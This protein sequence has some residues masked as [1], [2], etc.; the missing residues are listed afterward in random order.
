MGGN[1]PPAKSANAAV[2]STE[3]Y[4]LRSGSHARAFSRSTGPLLNHASHWGL[5]LPELLAVGFRYVSGEGSARDIA[6][7]ARRGKL[8][9]LG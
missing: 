6:T 7:A 3:G 4:L 8:S 1:G 2:P 9:D 5:S